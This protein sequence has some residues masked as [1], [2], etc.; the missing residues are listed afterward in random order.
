MSFIGPTPLQQKK[1]EEQNI[2]KVRAL[3]RLPANKKCFDC[4]T[5]S[6]FF[7]NVSIQTFVCSRC[8]GLV[9]EVGHRVKSISASTFSGQEV[10]A[11]QQGGN[12][13][14]KSIWLS[15]YRMDN[16]EPETDNDVRAFI[17]QKYYEHKWLDRDLLQSQT[18]KVQAIVK[19]M[20]TDEG[21]RRRGA[22]TPPIPSVS[23]APT[24]LPK[25]TRPASLQLTRSAW[26]PEITSPAVEDDPVARRQPMSA[27]EP[28]GSSPV[29]SGGFALPPSSVPVTPLKLDHTPRR[30]SQPPLPLPTQPYHQTQPQQ[31]QQQQPQLPQQQ[32]QQQPTT[33]SSSIF[34]ELAGL[35][36][37]TSK[38]ARRATYTG[39][40]LTPSTPGAP[41]PTA[42]Q[43]SSMFQTSTTTNTQQQNEPFK[44]TFTQQQQQQKKSVT[45][46]I[47]TTTTTTSKP[48]DDPY[49][50]LRG[51]TISSPE[52]PKQ[53]EPDI[54]NFHERQDS[55]EISWTGECGEQPPPSSRNILQE[56]KKR[57]ISII[58]DRIF[59]I[60]G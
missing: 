5:K 46:A 52:P 51:L 60:H 48:E 33:P 55:D 35:V 37:E 23:G 20:F 41:S 13:V 49:A 17:R 22:K 18:D 21:F 39:G 19:E 11:L 44:F 47:T 8:S 27:R 34:S 15:S 59:H 42:L 57:L 50:A 36:P 6:P 30:I 45:E 32:Q 26:K 25:P 16:V 28:S 12:E 4:P 7:V 31:Q 3:L 10:V 29:P 9:R 58:L 14:A 38:S 40:I 2:Q 24:P 54:P 56:K 1:Q 53:Q 43:F